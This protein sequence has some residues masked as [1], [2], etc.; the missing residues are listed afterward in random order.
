MSTVI[1]HNVVSVD[2]FIA[3]TNDQVGPLFD[4]LVN[5]DVDIIDGGEIK[6]SQ[7]SAGLRQDDVGGHRVDGDRSPPV[8]RCP[9][10]ARGP[11][12]SDPGQP[13]AAPALPGPPLAAGVRRHVRGCPS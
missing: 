12:H 1:M 6:V 2:G 3:D 7:A 9:A 11:A 8:G 5:G 10:S 13:G 4:W